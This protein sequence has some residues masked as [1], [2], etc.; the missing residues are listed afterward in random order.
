MSMLHWVYY[1]QPS[2]CPIIYLAGR[3]STIYLHQR[4]ANGV[5]RFDNQGN[6]RSLI[7]WNE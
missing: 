2:L 6:V 4:G 7:A 1:I 5:A 3:G